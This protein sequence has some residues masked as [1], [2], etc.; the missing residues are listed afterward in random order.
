MTMLVSSSKHAMA[1]ERM[2]ARDGFG[3]VKY[4]G[5]GRDSVRRERGLRGVRDWFL[6]ERV[7]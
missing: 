6:R 3:S 7:R 2:H 4:G 5:A 1:K